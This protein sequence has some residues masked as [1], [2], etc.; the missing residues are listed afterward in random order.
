[1]F[2]QS[3]KTHL[4]MKTMK[5]GNN[6][7]FYLFMY[8]HICCLMYVCIYVFMYINIPIHMYGKFLRIYV[9]AALH[10]YVYMYLCIAINM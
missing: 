7:L 9:F 3:V 1:M 10:T 4:K 8:I 6:P 2:T 5:K